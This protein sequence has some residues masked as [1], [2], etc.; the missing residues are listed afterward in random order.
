VFHKGLTPSKVIDFTYDEKNQLLQKDFKLQSNASVLLPPE[1]TEIYAHRL[2]SLKAQHMLNRPQIQSEL[3]KEASR[4][5]IESIR[6]HYKDQVLTGGY[7]PKRLN[8]EGQLIE[9][10]EKLIK[11][12]VKGGQEI[13]SLSAFSRPHKNT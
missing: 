2:F 10:E 13:I 8:E 11:N 4:V 1:S 6:N 3:K 12:Y 5:R 7:N 9:E